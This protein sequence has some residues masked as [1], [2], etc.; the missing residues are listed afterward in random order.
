MTIA[1]VLALIVGYLLY[2][3][4]GLIWGAGGALAAFYVAKAVL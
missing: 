2:K 1:L 3:S 4:K